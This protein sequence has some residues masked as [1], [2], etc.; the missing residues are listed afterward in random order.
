MLRGFMVHRGT[1]EARKL[2]APLTIISS[3]AQVGLNQLGLAWLGSSVFVM[4]GVIN[5]LL[6]LAVTFF[7]VDLIHSSF[8][9][10]SGAKAPSNA[11]VI[12]LGAE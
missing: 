12:D 6:D 5:N 4:L 7:W 3:L 11:E 9:A 10:R 8:A 2:I 1:T